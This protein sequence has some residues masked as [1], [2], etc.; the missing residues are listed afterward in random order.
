MSIISIHQVCYKI[1][2]TLYVQ[3][4]FFYSCLYSRHIVY[5]LHIRLHRCSQF[6]IYFYSWNKESPHCIEFLYHHLFLFLW[7][8]WVNISQRM[9]DE[10][11]CVF[12][13]LCILSEI[14]IVS[15]EKWN[16]FL[17]NSNKIYCNIK[18]IIFR[19]LQHV[20]CIKYKIKIKKLYL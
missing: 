16:I 20:L 18:D 19:R 17:N 11:L 10:F 12:I 1:S 5:V 6:Y 13:S 9:P 15:S 8:L 3:F 4:A 2:L 7:M 14:C